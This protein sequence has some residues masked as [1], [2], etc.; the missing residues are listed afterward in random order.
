MC[1]GGILFYLADYP[2][3]RRS[4]FTL[5][6]SPPSS[7]LSLPHLSTTISSFFD[8]SRSFHQFST[9]HQSL[10]TLVCHINFTRPKI[11]GSCARR[12]WTSGTTPVPPPKLD[13]QT[14][15]AKAKSLKPKYPSQS[16]HHNQIP[17]A[18]F[19]TVPLVPLL[20]SLIRERLSITAKIRHHEGRA[21][22]LGG[23]PSNWVYQPYSGGKERAEY[24]GGISGGKNA[25]VA[26]YKPD[27]PST[28]AFLGITL[29][30]AAII[31]SCE[32]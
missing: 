5:S 23:Q 25:K 30:Q 10:S 6:L 1:Q 29:V 13:Y 27:S 19:F 28:W 3:I 7:L 20:Q 31:L 18:H 9:L 15:Q 16:L 2:Q 17:A 24:P 22:L 26:M 4:S 11:A 12:Y 8:R 14:P 21:S 32:S